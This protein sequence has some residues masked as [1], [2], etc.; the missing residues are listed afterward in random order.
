MEALAEESQFFFSHLDSNKTVLEYGSGSS[1][2][3]IAA[4]C[5]RIVSVEHQPQWYNILLD[6]LPANCD[7]LLRT[8]NEKYEE[9]GVDDGSYEQFKN[10]VDAPIKFAPF[11]I[12]FIDG[13]A[14]VACAS[15]C[16]S[17]GHKD[18]IIFIHD[19]NREQYKIAEEYLTQVSQIVSMSKFTIKYD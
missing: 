2:F 14:R 18:T 8:P 10:Y 13:R 16:K 7:A 4:L 6:N 11:D 1:T 3:Q 19:Y 17:L 12:I 5:K 9:G 15:I